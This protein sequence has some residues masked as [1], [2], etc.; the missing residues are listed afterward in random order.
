MS[1]IRE[2]RQAVNMEKTVSNL[3]LIQTLKKRMSLSL[4]W[5]WFLFSRNLVQTDKCNPSCTLQHTT[6]CT[7][8]SC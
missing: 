7:G 5:A 8:C 4:G 3:I 1:V 6:D 2:S